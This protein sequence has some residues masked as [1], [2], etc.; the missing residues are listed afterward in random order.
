M[1]H[2]FCV[3]WMI[4]LLETRP[5]LP[6]F[7]L[8][9][10]SYYT[11]ATAKTTFL[12]YNPPMKPISSMKFSIITLLLPITSTTSPSSYASNEAMDS[13]SVSGFRALWM[14]WSTLFSR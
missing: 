10:Y 11:P 12:N 2:M 6:L 1:T 5:S 7:I 8:T 13:A 4:S 3:R 9:L 14:E